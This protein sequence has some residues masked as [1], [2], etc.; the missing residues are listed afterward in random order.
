MQVSVH[1]I[2]SEAKIGP[3]CD[4]LTKNDLPAGGEPN[5]LV[6]ESKDQAGFET[7]TLDRQE[8]VKTRHGIP[9]SVDLLVMAARQVSRERRR[10]SGAAH[11]HCFGD[12][13]LKQDLN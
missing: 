12:S 9:K 4:T 5:P 3:I 1:E 10:Y 2:A 6:S 7:E 8:H 13:V 11:G